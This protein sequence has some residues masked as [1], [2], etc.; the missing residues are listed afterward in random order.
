MCLQDR[1]NLVAGREISWTPRG[2]T[3]APLSIR[4]GSG[5]VCVI[6]HT[7]PGDCP[8]RRRLPK[9][10]DMAARLIYHMCKRAEW[11]AARVSGRYSG[12][13]QDAEDGFIHFS[14]E[15]Q[16]AGSA[17]KHRTGQRDLVILEVDAGLLGPALRWERSR[18]GEL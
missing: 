10:C 16:L 15:S 18:N 17:A 4:P 1:Q 7:R 2:R 8:T 9:V 14:T 3:R 11:E 12:S 13:S 6:C 5:S